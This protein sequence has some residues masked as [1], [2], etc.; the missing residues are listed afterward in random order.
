MREVPLDICGLGVILYSP[1]AVEHIMEGSDYFQLH[2]REPADVARHVMECQ[3]IAFCTG[4]PGTFRLRFADGAPDEQAVKAAAF[5]LRLGLQVRGG[6]VC[7]RDLYDLML[8]SDE[9]PESQQIP[10]ED[11]WYLLTVFTSPPPKGTFGDGQLIEVALERV[12]CKPALRW[13]GVPSLCG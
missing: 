3:L 6:A 5:K 8:W 10:V 7:I 13:D 1:P 12:E 4:S 2:F 11:G 9:C